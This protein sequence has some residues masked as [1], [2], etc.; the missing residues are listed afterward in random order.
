[1]NLRRINNDSLVDWE[2]IDN[3]P[4]DVNAELAWKQDTSGKWQ[5]NWYAW[6][7]SWGKVPL[8][9]LPVVPWSGDMT[10]AVYDPAWWAKQVAFADEVV[11]SVNWQT[12]V[13]V[14]DQD[15]IPTW[16]TN[17][18]ITIQEKKALIRWLSSGLL[19]WGVITQNWTNPNNIDISA[20][21]WVVIDNTDPLNPVYTRVTW[22]AFTNVVLTNI[23]TQPITNIY[24]DKNG[25][26][27]QWTLA[28]LNSTRRQ[29]VLLWVIEHILSPNIESIDNITALPYDTYVNLDEF[30]TTIWRIKSNTFSTTG[31]NINL[32]AGTVF[33][34]WDNK[35]SQNPNFTTFTAQ[36]TIS[37]IP[38]YRNWSGGWIYGTPTTSINNTQYDNGTWTLATLANNKATVHFLFWNS[39][40]NTF[41]L[42]LW[43]YQY[44][45]WDAAKAFYQSD[46]VTVNPLLTSAIFMW[47]VWIVKSGASVYFRQNSDRLWQFWV[48]GWSGW[49]ATDLQS[50]YN[51]SL[52]SA[53]I[54]TNTTN[55]SF[56]IRWWTGNNADAIFEGKNNAGTITSTL[57]AD[58]VPTASTDLVT[59]AYWDANYLWWSTQIRKMFAVAWTIW[60]TWVNV[61]NTV[62]MDRT[63]TLQQTNLWY[64]TAWNGTTTIDVNKNGTT[65]Y[66]TTKPWITTTNQSS[67]NSGTIT[68]AWC[69]SWDVYTLDIDAFAST[70][71]TDLYVELV[72]T[73]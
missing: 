49:S 2:K 12:W 25:N 22:N 48:W 68:T 19:S 58:G 72:F 59:K 50:S 27:Q 45:S 46:T 9:Q 67:I 53:E 71:W 17:S 26:L 14:L 37:F 69:V 41:Y 31:L 39:L 51:I 73:S 33:G 36:N 52:P 18:A 61:A 4:A 11:D 65:V 55:G 30:A 10:V 24:I 47:V 34:I 42:Q 38:T 8:S 3:L 32:S 1:M 15:D 57:R 64:W 63:A 5:A 7:D 6:L 40:S 29:N 21:E 56:T 62:V 54:T 66:A 44:D 70:P 35:N 23:A 28:N 13:V 20:W 16:T 43:Q 60:A